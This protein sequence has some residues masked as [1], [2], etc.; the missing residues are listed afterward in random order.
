[1]IKGNKISL[2]CPYSK[3][4]I[5]LQKDG[6]Y[7]ENFTLIYPKINGVYRIVQNEG[8]VA[9]FGFQWNKF[10]KTQIDK[11]KTDSIQ[12]A[13][14]FLS[15]TGWD[16]ENLE[17][18]IILE[19]GCG[20]GR[21]TKV[22]LQN[23]SAELHSI[24]YSKAVEACYEN[25][26]QYE[27][28]LYIY[29]A[30]IY[31]MPFEDKTF[32]KVFCFGVLQHTPNVEKSI[33]CL[34]EKT[35]TGGEIVVDFYPINNWYT[36]IHAKYLLRPITKRL[37]HETLLKLIEK[38]IDWMI[39]LTTFFSK[40]GIGKYVNRFIPICDIENTFPE[41]LTKEQIREWA[42]LDTFDMFSPQ[43]DNPQKIET[44]AEIF[45]K[46]N[47][48]ITFKGIIKYGKKGKVAVVKGIKQK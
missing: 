22:V 11:E 1:M 35:K 18:K 8:Y 26:K 41:N 27:D 31:E 16:K 34:I 13:E 4:K 14:R 29:Q 36:K 6:L 44:I 3:K 24:D 17:N 43:F 40:I 28:K 48:K 20:A 37:N 15:V 19:V 32:D 12:S 10:I 46:K 9:N 47:V 38:N 39:K 2:I 5:F 30:S 21:F 42:I 7:D 23:T 25:N 45:E 33:E